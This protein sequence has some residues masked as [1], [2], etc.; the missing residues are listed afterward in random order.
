MAQSHENAAWIKLFHYFFCTKDRLI[1]FRLTLIVEV[2]SAV[3]VIPYQ[4]LPITVIHPHKW[5]G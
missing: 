1:L 2:S 4:L 5:F 3:K